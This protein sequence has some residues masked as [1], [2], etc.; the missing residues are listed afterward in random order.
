[1][2][3]DQKEK[4]LSSLRKLY[5]QDIQYQQTIA[6]YANNF[7]Q[8]NKFL[9]K[10]FRFLV[11]RLNRYNISFDRDLFRSAL[12]EP[13]L[14]VELVPQTCWFSNV[15]DHVNKKT[16]DTLRKAT[17]KKAEYL[18][19]IC[20][21]RGDQWP[22]ECHEIWDYDDKNHIQI[23]K[24][25]IA[26][27]PKCHEVKHIGLTGLRGKEKEAKIHLAQVNAWNDEETEIY[28][29]KVWR[30]WHKRSQQEW[31]LDLSWLEQQG[32]TVKSKR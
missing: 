24:G 14:T 9:A 2:R 25:L 28:L 16:W 13:L 7:K 18:C 12:T 6:E 22:V 30:I 1:M 5:K 19:E 26:L 15:R 29:K 8:Q 10:E 17:Y 27:C 31:K 32:I 23:L 20:G 21:G 11:Q 4:I 3:A